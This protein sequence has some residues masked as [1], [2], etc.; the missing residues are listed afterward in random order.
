MGEPDPDHIEQAWRDAIDD[1][2]SRALAAHDDYPSEVHAIIKAEA[3]RR[4]ISPDSC[5]LPTAPPPSIIQRVGAIALRFVWAH[6][7]IAALAFGASVSLGLRFV[8]P[9]LGIADPRAWFVV[10]PVVYLSGLCLVCWPLRLYGV[11]PRTAL[12]A[13]AGSFLVGLLRL[14]YHTY[15]DAMTGG[16]LLFMLLVNLVTVW[17]VPCMLLSGGVFLHNRYWPVFP[18]GH[19][20]NC[21]YNLR[22]LPIPRCPEC[23]AAFD[24][25]ETLVDGQSV[26]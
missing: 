1:D 26:A 10:L 20:K 24:P 9:I 22:G 25:T 16:D 23:G 8:M 4:G 15:F 12:A 5:V 2:V 11:V 21:G 3:L 13:W 7:I 19:C 14:A 18:A 17:L 6:R